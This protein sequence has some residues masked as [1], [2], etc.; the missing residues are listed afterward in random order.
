MI[1]HRKKKK[2][3]LLRDCPISSEAF[4]YINNRRY[5]TREP[6][7]VTLDRILKQHERLVNS[8][9]LAKKDRDEEESEGLMVYL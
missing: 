4:M 2:S 7:Y 8:S 1:S 3:N 6:L 9:N 5:S